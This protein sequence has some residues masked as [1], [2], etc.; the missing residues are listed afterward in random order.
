MSA[1]AALSPVYEV[2]WFKFI[3]E[4]YGDHFVVGFPRIIHEWIIILWISVFNT[5]ANSSN[6][7][8]STMQIQ[9]PNYQIGV[10]IRTSFLENNFL[11]MVFHS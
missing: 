4:V 1:E 2:F 3:A 5:F 10:K 8:H 9:F 6:I 7:L 11:R